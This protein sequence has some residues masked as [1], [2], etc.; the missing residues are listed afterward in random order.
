MK[1]KN[2]IGDIPNR[3]DIQGLPLCFL[4]LNIG[5]MMTKKKMLEK[6]EQ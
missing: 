3:Y 5:D 1:K 2:H 6:Y 4:R